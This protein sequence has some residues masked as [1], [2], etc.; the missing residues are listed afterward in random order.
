MIYL[1]NAATTLQKPPCV[2]EAVVRA[3]DTFGNASRGAHAPALD[4]L[5]MLMEARIALASLFGVDDPM[6]VV[7]A[8]NA[9]VAL[10]IAISGIRGHIVTTAAEHNSVLRPIYKRGNY[11]IVP[12]DSLGCVSTEAISSAIR[13]DTGAVVLTHASNVTGNVFDIQSVGELC[14]ERGLD[15]IVDASQ[16]AGLLP[17]EMKNISALCFTGHKS[18][19]GPQ[20]TGGLCLG[21]NYRPE[22]LY[23]GGSGH[24]SFDSKHPGELPDAL[25]AGTQNAHGIAGLLAGVQYIQSTGLSTIHNQADTWARLFAHSLAD[26]PGVTLY[27]DLAAPLRTPIVSLNIQGYDSAQVATLLFEKYGIAVR[28][29]AHCAP[30]M[31][32]GLKL[33]GSVR[34]SFSHFNTREETLFVADAVCALAASR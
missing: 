3:M 32:D 6:R 4:A 20:G 25:E 7:F 13:P 1:D 14:A 17:I 24:H 10:N 21:P 15:F 26:I 11:T 34:F 23:V 2:K 8:P 33:S 22:S 12:C 27:G 16:S 28:A 19:F 5:R 31:H 9:T 18:L 29:G 30:L